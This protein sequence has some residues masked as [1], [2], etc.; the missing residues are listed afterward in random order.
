MTAPATLT[1][2]ER[3]CAGTRSGSTGLTVLEG[4]TDGYNGSRSGACQ[5]ISRLMPYDNALAETVN[6]LY[7]AELGHN[8]GPWRDAPT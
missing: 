3:A 8:F 7:K 1:R 6:G 4:R 2:V 5:S